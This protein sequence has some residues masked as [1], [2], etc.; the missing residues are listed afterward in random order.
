MYTASLIMFCV[1][2]VGCYVV[3]YRFPF[4]KFELYAGIGNRD[5]AAVPLF[6]V[7]DQEANIWDYHQFTAL[8]SDAFL[9]DTIPTSVTW[10]AEEAARWVRNHPKPEGVAEGPHRVQWGY[11]LLRI[12]SQ[13]EIIEER[14]VLTEGHAW[15][16]S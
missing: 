10:M 6:L 15:K 7:E 8:D 16:R 4:D 9:N 12:D 14:L 5:H 3:G 11:R 1:Y 13:G 2:L